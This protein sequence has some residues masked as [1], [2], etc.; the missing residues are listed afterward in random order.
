MEAN[1]IRLLRVLLQDQHLEALLVTNRF[2]RAYMT[3]FTGSSGC[4]LITLDRAYLFTDF[5]YRSQAPLQ[6]RHYE[7]IEHGPKVLESVKATLQELKIARLGFEQSDVSFALYSMIAQELEGIILVP[8]SDV[9]EELRM[10]KSVEELQIMQEAADLADRTFTHILSF[11]RPGIPERDIALEIEFFMRKA[12]AASSSFETIV[13]SGERSALP[14]GIASDRLLGSNEFVKLDFGAYYKGYCSDITRTIMLGKPSSKHKEIYDV[15]LEA[16]LNALEKIQPGMTGQQA[17]ALTRD[18]IISYGYGDHFGHGTGHG[19]G[20]EI[21][22]APRLTRT[23]D[24]VLKPGM[25][26]TV[27]P[28]VYIPDFGGVRIE[29][30]I[31]ITETGLRILTQSTKDFTIID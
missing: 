17:D 5:R 24:T 30:D 26:V 1:R 4:V 7:V 10:I 13:A 23:S 3:G 12:G 31:V 18:I 19:L 2:N 6:A 27:E 14:H 9:V 25:T 28:G 29:D 8:V 22:E 16:Q 11:L 15:V 20:M 21:H